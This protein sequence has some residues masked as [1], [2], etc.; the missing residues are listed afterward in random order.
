MTMPV[1]A[2]AG[3]AASRCP[4][5]R[6]VVIGYHTSVQRRA[7]GAAHLSPGARADQRET[8]IPETVTGALDGHRRGERTAAASHSIDSTLPGRTTPEGTRDTR[9]GQTGSA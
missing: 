1:P 4:R 7:C 2:G 3:I 5:L 9:M 8:I 6:R